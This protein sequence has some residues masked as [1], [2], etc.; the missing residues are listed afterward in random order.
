MIEPATPAVDAWSLNHWTAREA[1]SSASLPAALMDGSSCREASA[2]AAGFSVL[3]AEA[4][5]AASRTQ[6]PRGDKVERCLCPRC[7]LHTTRRVTAVASR[8]ARARLELHGRW[9][10]AGGWG[11]CCSGG[12]SLSNSGMFELGR[13]GDVTW[14]VLT[15]VCLG[16]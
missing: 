9:G 3:R 14:L 5:E 8:V 15:H 6:G 10:S 13:R 12:V 2:G 7:S 11:P 1:P 4:A 16:P